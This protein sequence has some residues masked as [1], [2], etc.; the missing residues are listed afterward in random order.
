MAFLKT[1]WGSTVALALF[2][3]LCVAPRLSFSQRNKVMGELEFTASNQEFKHAGVWADGQYVGY[4]D[5]LKGSKAIFLLPGKHE[6]V[7]REAGYNDFKEEIV[8]EPGQTRSISVTLTKDPRY[9]LPAVTSEI[10]LDVNPSRAAVFI[11]GSFLGPVSDFGGMG[12]ALLVSPGKHHIKLA[13][14]GYQDFETDI[15]VVA[16][17]KSTIKTELVKGSITQAGQ[18]IKEQ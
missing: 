11:D 18:P 4:V 9:H 10:K 12:R 15:T 5:E 17:Q 6:I 1:Y 8:A 3:L 16:N 2:S 13:L 14:P 7:V